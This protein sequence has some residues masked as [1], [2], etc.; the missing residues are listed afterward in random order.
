MRALGRRKRPTIN[1]YE[2]S[3]IREKCEKWAGEIDGES[4]A[5]ASTHAYIYT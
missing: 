5:I 2:M 3:D 4:N 1:F